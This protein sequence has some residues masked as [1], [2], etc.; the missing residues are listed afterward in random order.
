MKIHKLSFHEKEKGG[1]IWLYYLSHT[2]RGDKARVQV[3]GI[4]S[5]EYFI[6]GWDDTARVITYIHIRG[7]GKG[8]L[9]LYSS[10]SSKTNQA[11][12]L[13]HEENR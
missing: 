8:V 5:W 9:P 1:R 11:P 10:D 13:C 6:D 2:T 3:M 12:I 4:T 7:H